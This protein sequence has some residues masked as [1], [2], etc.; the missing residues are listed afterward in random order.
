M[1]MKKYCTAIAILIAINLVTSAVLVSLM[2]DQVPVH[3]GPGGVVD[4]MGSKYETLAL[5][6]A[7]PLVIG[8]VS[9]ADARTSDAGNKTLK[10]R[11]GAL[12]QVFFIGFS[13]YM[14]LSQLSFDGAPAPTAAGLDVSQFSAVFIGI[15]LIVFGNLMP[16]TTRNSTFGIRLPWS[17]ENDEVWQKTQR[18]GGYATIAAGL[19]AVLCGILFSGEATFTAL[20]VVILAWAAAC[21]IISYAVYRQDRERAADEDGGDE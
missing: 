3:F 11:L 21:G 9:I 5:M 4:R 1:T 8:V 16:K 14:G 7:L 13:V 17:M 6:A 18:L 20:M 12:V 10:L 19:T 2:P 15:L